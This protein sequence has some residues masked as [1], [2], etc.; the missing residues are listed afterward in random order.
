MM[1]G[2]IGV[3]SE[4][5]KGSTFWFTATFKK[6]SGC[7][8]VLPASNAVLSGL[9]VMVLDDIESIREILTEYLAD[10]E[11]DTHAC[12]D[13]IQALDHIEAAARSSKP[14]D[15]LL[16]DIRMPDMSGFELA[17]RIR[18][19]AA[20]SSMAIILFSG[21]N[22]IGDGERCRRF[23]VDGYLTKPVKLAELKQA[24]E[25]VFGYAASRHRERRPLVTR[26]SL[27]EIHHRQHRILLAEDYPTNQ[28]VALSHMRS[29]G[30]IVDLVENGQEA[31]SAYE[32]GTY[33]MIIMDMQMPI[34][35]G[36][37][38]IGMIRHMESNS[39]RSSESSQHIPII[40]VTANAMK[41]DR[42][43]CLAAGADDYI[44]KPLTKN[45]LLA[46]IGKWICRPVSPN[47]EAEDTSEIESHAGDCDA[48][49]NYE[50]ILNEFGNEADVLLSVL[51]GFIRD[52]DGQIQKMRDAAINRNSETIAREAHA[53]K[54]GGANLAANDV[55]CAA[56]ELEKIG[57][58]GSLAR[59][60]DKIEA[61]EFEI[62][63]LDV[64]ARRMIRKQQQDNI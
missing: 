24:I 50:H 57:T 42:E 61:L 40:A 19:H 60:A 39:A 41:E 35:D 22:E 46:T 10:F 4:P 1:G 25:M 2:E 54:G 21:I 45:R 63:R 32:R 7:D 56:E 52:A 59:A 13:P 49:L 6:A 20:V 23:G 18:G 55:A 17:A 27:A 11:M 38:A 15:L 51:T 30:H 28:Q 12:S 8:L 44:S 58:C 34:M 53:I 14:F 64:F 26:H 33:D 48:P 29:A 36:Y 9:K 62:R 43:K 3:V 37:K 47:T 5:G 16:S 31:V